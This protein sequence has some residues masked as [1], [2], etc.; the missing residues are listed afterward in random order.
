M[1]YNYDRFDPLDGRF[2]FKQSGNML[3]R[4][5]LARAA[6]IILF[7]LSAIV[8]I[9]SV[10]FWVWSLS[11][12]DI[13]KAHTVGGTV[14]QQLITNSAPFMVLVLTVIGALIIW[15]VTLIT[16]MRWL[17]GG[18]HHYEADDEALTI[19]FK[20]YADVIRYD[21]VLTV[22]FKDLHSFGARRSL[23]VTVTTIQGETYK[24]CYV[25]PYKGILNKPE[26]SPFYVLTRKRY[27]KEEDIGIVF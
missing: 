14:Y 18:L 2:E 3:L 23:R 22:D 24:Y 6:V 12:D 7:S 13:D 26:D 25:P 11:V 20:N 19:E 9:V 4:S 5:E 10:P 16:I 21:D 1:S 27:K 15:T 8:T 17:R